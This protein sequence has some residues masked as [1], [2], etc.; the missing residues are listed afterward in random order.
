MAGDSFVTLNPGSGG[1]NMASYQDASNYQHQKIVLETETPGSDPVKVNASN[2][3]PAAVAGTVASGASNTNNPVKVGGA[4]NSSAPTLSSGQIG[5]L[6]L[7]SAGN[8]KI[9]IVAGA[10]A[11][12]TSS[13]FSAAFPSTGTA[14]GAS[15]G[16]NMSPLLVDGSGNLKVNVAAGSVPAGQD[17]TAFTA[18][19]TQGLPAL[20]VADNTASVSNAAQGNEGVLKMTLSRQLRV[21]VDAASSGGLSYYN[22]IQPATPAATAVKTSAGQ[23]GFIHATNNNATPVYLKIFNVASGS[24]TLGTTSAN[25]NLEI[26]G[27]TGGAGFVLPIPCGL[28]FGTAITIATTA[29]I[30]ATDDTSLANGTSVIVTVGYA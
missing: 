27:N 5:D 11:G 12:G 19:T 14:V 6:Q 22:G 16:T 15:N 9:N 8:L 18:G 21:V 23:I 2:P 28:S 26:P 3:L 7:D 29:G 1:Q 25:L 24:V 13:T 10:A 17:N 4:Y 20:A 30:G